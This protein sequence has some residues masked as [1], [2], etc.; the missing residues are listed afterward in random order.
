MNFRLDT[1]DDVGAE[2]AEVTELLVAWVDVVVVA[3]VVG[4]SVFVVVSLSV[5]RVDVGPSDDVVA[6]AIDGPSDDAAAGADV[7]SPDSAAARF[8][9]AR[10]PP[11]PPPIPPARMTTK[12]MITIQNVFTDNPSIVFDLGSGS[13]GGCG[14]SG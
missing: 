6:G 14:M 3:N 2:A 11:T 13:V 12:T 8:F 10:P 9:A 7:G 5:T 1:S 4:S